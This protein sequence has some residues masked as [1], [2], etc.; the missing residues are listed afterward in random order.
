M[1]QTLFE[2][3]KQ[4]YALY[5]FKRTPV[6]G[7]LRLH[8]QT[9]FKDTLLRSMSWEAKEKHIGDFMRRVGAMFLTTNPF[10]AYRE[11]LASAAYAYA[12]LQVLCLK[13]EEKTD[14]LD[15]PYIS[16]ELYRHLRALKDHHDEIARILW[17]HPEITDEELI[18]T[19]NAETVL[20]LYHLNG[21]NIIR[22]EI[23]HRVLDDPKDWF[24]PLVKST[25]IFAENHHRNQLGLPSLCDEIGIRALEHATLMDFVRNGHQQPLFEWERHYNLVHAEAS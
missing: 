24:K 16:G 6:A 15:S 21:L 25:L 14:V 13:P 22:G 19:L 20:C 9:Y 11:E 4:R 23:E 2:A 5:K 1:P 18:A 3:L 12:D 17:Q 8:T 10:L 7:A